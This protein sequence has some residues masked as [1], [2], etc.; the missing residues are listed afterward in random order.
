[1]KRCRLSA[2][3]LALLL[4]SLTALPAAAEDTLTLYGKITVSRTAET[5]DLQDIRVSNMDKFRGYLD[6]LPALKTVEMPGSRLSLS[7]LEGLMRD[8]PGIDFGVRFGF[9]KKS[10]STRQTAFSTMNK[11]EDPRYPEDRFTAIKYCKDLRALD[12][13][14]NALRDL[15]FLTTLPELRVLIVADNHIEDLTPLSRLKN[16]EYLELFFNRFTD[17]S[18]L[19]ELTN[20]RDLNLCRNKISD[21]TPLLGLTNL[22][23]LWLPDNFLTAEQKAEL[24]A[25]LPNC[26]IVYEWSRSTSF[27]WRYHPRYTIVRRMF[28]QGVYEPFEPAIRP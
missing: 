13:G 10:I 6:Q 25:A 21:V 3:L 17:L 8:Y 14:H 4:A 27:G 1:M 28:E 15:T 19:A 16:L 5:L 9:V 12:L 11:P 23:R 18:P 7:Q 24:E 20:L 2:L 26:Q 22:E